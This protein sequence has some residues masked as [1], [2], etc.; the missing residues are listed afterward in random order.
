MCQYDFEQTIARRNVGSGKWDE[1]T[2]IVD[3]TEDIIPFSVADME[4]RNMPEVI[5][6]LKAFLDSSILGYANP[7]MA[8]REAVCRWMERR[9]GWSVQPE[10]L[11]DTP[12]VI[13]AFFT[14]VKAFTEPGDGILLMTP[15]YY[16]MYM[17]AERNGRKVIASSLR[18]RDG[19]YEIDFDDFAEKVRRPDTK[20]LL[21]CSPHNPTGRVWTREELTRIGQLCIDHDVLICSDEIHH[22]LIMPG[23]H[24][25]MFGSISEAFAQ[26]SLVCTAPSK[27]FNLAGLQTSNVIIPN[28]EL[29]QHYVTE[30]R[31]G[32][33]NPK[34]NILGLEG[35]R[36]AYTHGDAWLEQLLRLV[37]TNRQ[38]VEAFLQREFPMVRVTPL[39]GTYLLWIDFRALGLDAKALDRALREEG[40]LFFDEGSIF[41]PEGAGF[42]RWNLAC[43]TSYIQA[44]L[45]RLKAVLD[46]MLQK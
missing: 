1:M 29:R 30:M 8:Y 2:G 6:G 39:E 4:L 18:C 32:D 34:C 24:H 19:R 33:G 13:H 40:K 5:E 12:G 7:T 22:D 27:T 45:P 37:D 38:T 21:L 42:E 10:W 23:Y 16:P 43:P 35:C 11:V 15:V 9:H 36:L 41:G 14:A 28:E 31:K 25:T 44:A 20:L 17:A 3:E 46:G 26:H